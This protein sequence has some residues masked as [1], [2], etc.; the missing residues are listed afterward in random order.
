MSLGAS[1]VFLLAFVLLRSSSSAGST[2]CKS[3][4][5]RSRSAGKSSPSGATLDR[6]VVC[7][8]MELHQVPSPESFPNRT[9]SLDIKNNIIAHIEPGAFY[10]LFALKRLDLSKNLIGCLHV[11]V[12]KGLTNLVKL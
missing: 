4:D 7:S 11:D 9:V 1:C 3:Y 10:G 8:N 6:K 12:F 5:E 2:E